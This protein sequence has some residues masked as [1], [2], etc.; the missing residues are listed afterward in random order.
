MTSNNLSGWVLAWKFRWNFGILHHLL[1]ERWK[2][3]LNVE[4]KRNREEGCWFGVFSPLLR[5]W[6]FVVSFA[7]GLC[8]LN[9]LCVLCRLLTHFSDRNWAQANREGSWLAT[10]QDST[11]IKLP[12]P[13]FL[14]TTQK[15]SFVPRTFTLPPR[16]QGHFFLFRFSFCGTRER[17]LRT[18][19]ET[20]RMTLVFL[21]QNPKRAV[22]MG[23][24]SVMLFSKLDF[25]GAP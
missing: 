21:A 22:C 5:V 25:V 4:G 16:G 19:Q 1:P 24:F 11:F 23:I 13:D 15:F 9:P 8:I 2:R 6:L 20:M 12:S 18:T 14:S 17:K 10:P 3:F 7:F